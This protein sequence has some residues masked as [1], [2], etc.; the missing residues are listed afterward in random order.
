MADKPTKIMWTITDE[1]PALATY[2]LLPVIERFTKAAGVNV[3]PA[4]ISVAARILAGFPECLTEAQRKPDTLAALGE[5]AK[6]P[7]AN[8][9]KLPN[10]STSIPQLN[11]AIAELRAKGYMVPPYPQEPKDDAEKAIKEKYSKVLG[12]AVDPVLREGNSDRRVAGPVKKFAQKNPHKLGAWPADSR[13]HVATMSDGDFFSAEQSTTCEKATEVRIEFVPAGGGEAQVLKPSVKL[14]AGELIDSSRMSAKALREYIEKELTDCKEKGLMVSLHLKATM[15]KISD[16]ILFGHV[17]TV[18]FKDVFS[19][20]ADAL[21]K[22]GVNPNNGLA[23]LYEKIKSLP[24][25][26]RKAIEADI[27][28]AYATRPSLAMVDSDRGI[29]NLHVPSDVIID[30][31][32]PV[33]VRDSGRMWNKAGELEDVKCLIPDRSYGPMYQ[34]CVAD[35][36]KNGAFDVATMGNVSNVGLMAQKVKPLH[37]SRQKA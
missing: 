21:A 26:E 34:A 18:F 15:M 36:Q 23:A 10:V 11:E 22:A 1:A 33:V 29:T 6:T 17:L 2:A 12:S 3:E 16:P 19:K 27:D 37:R 13:T 25:A 4:D 31:S 20:H 35:C 24:D 9:V 28:A 7:R 32:M 8:I 14:Q 30:A 5:L